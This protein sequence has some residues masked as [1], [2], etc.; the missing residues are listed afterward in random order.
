M[1]GVKGG[2]F[3]PHRVGAP[4]HEGEGGRWPARAVASGDSRTF[5]VGHRTLRC[6]R[7]A[8]T[9][10]PTLRSWKPVLSAAV[11]VEAKSV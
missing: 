1:R 10:R 5:T 6:T 8:S 2:S 11:V 9:G 4:L 7:G 3:N